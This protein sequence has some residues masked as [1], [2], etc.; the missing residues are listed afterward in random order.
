MYRLK[1][2]SKSEAGQK[3]AAGDSSASGAEN[4]LRRLALAGTNEE[5]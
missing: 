4:D 1:R 5:R 2:Q 3:R